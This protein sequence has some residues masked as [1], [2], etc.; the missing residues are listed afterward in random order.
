MVHAVP[1]RP[2]PYSLH[3]ID[4]QKLLNRL[5]QVA[6][7]LHASPSI[8]AIIVTMGVY[9]F[10]INL[11]LKCLLPAQTRSIFNSPI[12]TMELQLSYSNKIYSAY[13]EPKC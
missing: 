9:F 4:L 7:I 6:T 3:N 13:I 8:S 12:G 11:E 2:I 5:Q 1:T 10:R